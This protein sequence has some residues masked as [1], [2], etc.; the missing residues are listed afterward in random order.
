MP[1]TSRDNCIIH[2]RVS[3]PKQAEQ[4]D[5]LEAQEAI[6]RGVAERRGWRVL[7]VFH[8]PYSGRKH[9]R[10]VVDEIVQYI[11]KSK[12]PV[13]Y[14]LFKGIDRLTRAGVVEYQTLKERLEKLGVTVV[15]SYGVIQPKQNTLDHLGIAYDW[16]VYAPSETAE[17]LEAHRGK[18][19]VRDILTRMIGAEIALT[20]EGFKVR[21]AADGFLNKKV[22]LDG[23][24]RV[25]EV[26]DPER[27]NFFR[28]L[29]RLRAE[30]R[31]SDKAITARINAMGY[32]TRRFRRWDREH[33]RIIGYT[34]PRPLSVKRLQEIVKRPIYCGVRVEKW[35]GGRPI[36]TRYPGLVS[37]KTWNAANRGKVRID[38]HPDGTL[39]IGQGGN[40]TP[41]RL[42]NNPLYPY[43]SVV[44]CPLC[45]KPFLGSAS[46]GRAGTRYPAYHCN[47]G[48][49]LRI[50]KG[51]FESAV[52]NYL[53]RLRPDGLTKAELRRALLK[54]WEKRRYEVQEMTR[55]VQDNIRALRTAQ[56]SALD[57]LMSAETDVVRRK[58]ETRVAELDTQIRDAEAT[59][60]ADQDDVSKREVEAFADWAHDLMEHPLPRLSDTT[61]L[62]LQRACFALVF[63]KLPTYKDILNGTPKLSPLF[64]LIGLLAMRKSPSVRPPVFGWNQLRVAIHQWRGIKKLAGTPPPVIY[65][66][67]R[68]A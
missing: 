36:R 15:D 21:Q 60:S 43:R 48:H 39:S 25:I 61:N 22:D 54:I 59:R 28:E 2:C 53:A 30:G 8:E 34:T 49:Y 29:F 46:R 52:E 31:L 1:R 68:A 40:A 56:E 62:E 18:Q 19:E 67:W 47:R 33:S 37:I 7:K 13:H 6:G 51:D 41:V 65:P 16:S 12:P 35:T 10:P 44:L 42:R 9:D 24:K 4:G 11:R 64:C 5:S 3:T 57:A 27:A 20:R 63:D 38:E 32:R 66:K 23:R 45:G 14:Y 50:P 55:R 17:M 58:L 26:P